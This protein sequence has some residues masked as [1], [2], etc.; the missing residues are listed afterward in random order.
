[1]T[2]RTARRDQRKAFTLIE[3]LVVIAIIA[4]LIGLLLPAVQQVRQASMRTQC[5]NNLKQICLASMNY[6]SAYGHLPPGCASSPNGGPGWAT[7]QGVPAAYQAFTGFG[8]TYGP[9]TVEAAWGEPGPSVGTLVYLLPYIEEGA[10]FSQIDPG[11]M[12]PNSTYGAVCYSGPPASQAPNFGNQTSLPS[13]ACFT[14]KKFIC[15]ADPLAIAGASS[16][17]NIIDMWF[18][19][20]NAAAG[21]GPYVYV[22]YFEVITTAPTGNTN[23]AGACNYISCGGGF[24]NDKTLACVQNAYYGVVAPYTSTNWCGIYTVGSTTKIVDVKD[25]TSNTIAFGETCWG[26]KV[27]LAG[28]TGPT[29]GTIGFNWASAGGMTLPVGMPVLPGNPSHHEYGS[30]HNNVV[31]MAFQDGSVRMISAST[32]KVTLWKLSSMFDGYDINWSLCGL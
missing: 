32:D 27:G 7:A 31:T 29:A 15:P 17:G 22:D 14:I 26:R 9:N 21:L 19:G 20:P 18:N 2:A 5:Q 6:E 28:G 16:V 25:G 23:L 24:G 12:D 8:N 3:L 10:I 11:F 1:M 13:W 4:I 30:K